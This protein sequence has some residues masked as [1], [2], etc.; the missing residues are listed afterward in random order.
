MKNNSIHLA[1]NLEFLREVPDG[2]ADLIYI[3]PPF[4]TGSQQSITRI[5]TVRD[6]GGDRTGFGGGT[7]QSAGA[8]VRTSTPSMTTWLSSPPASRRPAGC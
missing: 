6:E 4:N 1:D 5:K 3:D 7:G 2:A 8:A